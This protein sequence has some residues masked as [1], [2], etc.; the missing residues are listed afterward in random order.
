M[1]NAEFVRASY[2]GDSWIIV[3]RLENNGFQ[4]INEI[5]GESIVFRRGET[6]PDDGMIIIDGI[7]LIKNSC[8]AIKHAILMRAYVSNDERIVK[9]IDKFKLHAEIEPF[10]LDIVRH[11]LEGPFMFNR[12]ATDGESIKYELILMRIDME[13]VIN[14]SQ[15][16]A[17]FR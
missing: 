6:D 14:V 1:A 4:G 10:Y 11:G 7:D 15:I 12:L 9:N 16:V 8:R 3:D 5:S 13:Y 2:K 17:A